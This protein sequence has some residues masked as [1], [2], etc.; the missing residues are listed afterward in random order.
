GYNK[1]PSKTWFW[2]EDDW[3]YITYPEGFRGR[4]Y[5]GFVWSSTMTF[6]LANVYMTNLVKCGLNNAEG[7]FQ[8]ISSFE[9]KAVKNCFTNF[10]KKEISILKPKVIFAVGSA[11]ERWV[12]YFVKDMKYTCFVQQLPHPAARRRNDHFRAIYF[13]G[14]VRALHKAEIINTDEG[15]KLAK[16][17]LDDYDLPGDRLEFIGILGSE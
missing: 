8:G 13:W 10:L 7:Q 5:G 3:P 9:D 15:C 14:V 17:Y 11:V 1:H 2:I 16:L 4:K 6:K 12:K